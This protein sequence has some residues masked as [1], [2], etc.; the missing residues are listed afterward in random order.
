MNRRIKKKKNMI[1]MEES[2]TGFRNGL[3][4]NVTIAYNRYG[5]QEIYSQIWDTAKGKYVKRRI[6]KRIII[7]VVKDAPTA[8]II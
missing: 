3:I 4:Y 5:E 6:P 8:I 2:H 1:G 7:Q